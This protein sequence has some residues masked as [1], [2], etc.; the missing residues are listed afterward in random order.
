MIWHDRVDDY[1]RH[2]AIWKIDE[3]VEK[4]RATGSDK[5]EPVLLKDQLPWHMPFLEVAPAEEASILHFQSK[6]DDQEWKG[7][8]DAVHSMVCNFQIVG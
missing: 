3:V 5:P 6:E 4:K 8:G 1:R 2:N 7:D